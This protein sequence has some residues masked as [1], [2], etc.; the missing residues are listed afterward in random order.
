MQR[1]SDIDELRMPPEL[2]D[3]LVGHA[4]RKLR[5][6]YEPGEEAAPKAYGLVG[7]RPT[8]TRMDV[9]AVVPLR[10]NLRDDPRYKAYF[11]DLMAAVA[12]PSETPMSRRGWV[13]A[14][15]E[16][17]AAQQ[18]CEDAGAVLFAG[19]HMHRVPWAHDPRRDTCTE[20]DRRLAADSGLWTLILS[21][22][23]PYRPSLRA[24][25]EGDN[26]HEARIRIGVRP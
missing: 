11:D 14:P 26:A 9:T 10:R 20:L 8:G 5:G 1:L 7:G 17:A 3:Q 12:A 21:M 16:V 19:Y 4:H 23:T 18:V 25:F 15:D 2:F 6:E 24:F 13:A 22:V